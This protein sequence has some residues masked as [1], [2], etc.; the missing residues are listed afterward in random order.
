MS[1]KDKRGFYLESFLLF[2]YC[3]KCMD[4][5]SKLPSLLLRVLSSIRYS[6]DMGVSVRCIFSLDKE[7]RLG[8]AVSGKRMAVEFV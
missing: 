8:S 2:Q 4:A 3:V 5:V 1:C 6:S 7:A